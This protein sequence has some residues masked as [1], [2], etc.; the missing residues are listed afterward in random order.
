[1]PESSMRSGLRVIRSLPTRPPPDS[2]TLVVLSGTSPR[3]CC[4]VHSVASPRRL[5]TGVDRLLT[6]S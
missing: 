4:L 2:M 5:V 6:S 1:M 3:I